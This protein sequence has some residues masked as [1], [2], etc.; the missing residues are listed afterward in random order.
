MSTE[1]RKTSNLS[2]FPPLKFDFSVFWHRGFGKEQQNPFSTVM[3]F[4]TIATRACKWA[5]GPTLWISSGSLSCTSGSR[6]RCFPS[7]RP[8]VLQG[9]AKAFGSASAI[10]RVKWKT[11]T[12]LSFWGCHAQVIWIFHHILLH[13]C[14][15]ANFP[16]NN[17]PAICCYYT[18]SSACHI[19][20]LGEFVPSIKYLKSK[21]LA[22]TSSSVHYKHALTPKE[23]LLQPMY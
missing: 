19:K 15:E 18:T 23:E 17:P 7:Q 22:H 11:A 6:G 13:F 5:V 16:P 10:T 14:T 8:C 2:L 4:I 21:L 9:K 1:T 20:H 12:G 3:W